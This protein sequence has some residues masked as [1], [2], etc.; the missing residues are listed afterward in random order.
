MLLLGQA[1]NCECLPPGRHSQ[2]GEWRSTASAGVASAVALAL[3][4]APRSRLL[5]SWCRQRRARAAALP[6]SLLHLLLVSAFALL[7]TPL[8]LS[9]YLLF[10]HSL[11]LSLSTTNLDVRC[12]A[13][14][15]LLA[16]ILVWQ[17]SHPAYGAGADGQPKHREGAAQ[18]KKQPEKEVTAQEVQCRLSNDCTRSPRQ[19]K[20]A[21]QTAPAVGPRRV[22]W[23]SG[24]N[25]QF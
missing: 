5:F 22:R 15:P 21:A 20:V 9:L 8:P 11:S 25:C 2:F 3:A 18:D 14:R 10:W 19:E 6:P 23:S 4:F 16:L 1:P 12:P 17:Y 24:T 13:A 7:L